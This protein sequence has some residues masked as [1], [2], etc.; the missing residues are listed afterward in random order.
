MNDLEWLRLAVDVERADA[1]R[2]LGYDPV[3][4]SER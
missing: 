1:V 2:I 3:I 4:E